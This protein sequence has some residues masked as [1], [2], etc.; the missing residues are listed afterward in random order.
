VF[1]NVSDDIFYTEQK[2][3]FLSAKI[4]IVQKAGQIFLPDKKFF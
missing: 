2:K 4:K 1:F 3:S